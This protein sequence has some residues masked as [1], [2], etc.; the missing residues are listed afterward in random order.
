MRITWDRSADAAYLH[1]TA[2]ELTPG[3]DTVDVDGSVL[4]DRKDGR[5]VGIEVLNASA[6]LPPDLLAEAETPA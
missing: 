6:L 4:L 3:R 1:L 5:L 2:A